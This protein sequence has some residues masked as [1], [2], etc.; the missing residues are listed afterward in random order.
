MRQRLAGLVLM[1]GCV[2]LM[3]SLALAQ[4]ASS[5]TSL[6]GTVKDKDGGVIPGATVTITNNATGVTQTLVTNGEGA[7]ASPAMN[8]GTYTVTIEMSG[9]RKAEYR[10]VRLLGSQ[11]ATINTVLEIGGLTDTVTVTSATDLVRLE[12]PTISSTVSGEFIKSVPA[13]SR[14]ALD[15]MVFLPGVETPGANARE[16]RISGL[17][18][19]TIN[20][21]ID[22]VSTSNNLQS[23]DGFFTMVTPRLD[24]VE[25]VTLT[26]AN[27]GADSSAHGATQV[28][29]VTKSGTNRFK[30]TVYEY[31][32][33][34]SL[35]T[36]TFFNRLNG[37]ERPRAT[38]NT[39]G[40]S[41]GGPI[42][43]PGLFDGRNKAF[44]FF[45]QE[46]SDTPRQQARERLILREGAVN[47]DFRYGVT[48]PRT[49][50]VLALAAANGQLATHDPTVL[51][52][53]NSI[54]AATKTTGTISD[55][56][57]NPNT[58]EYN[59]F[60]PV[61]TTRN[62]PT[63]R[64]DL[65][66][67]S[68]HRLSGTYYLQRYKDSPDTL[69]DADMSFPGFPAWAYQNSYRTTGS[70]AFRSTLSSNLVNEALFGWQSSP[71]DFFGNSHPDMFVHQAGFNTDFNFPTG[72][73]VTQLTNP[74]PGAANAPQPRNTPNFNID[75]N[76]SW[77]KGS[78]SLKFGASFTRIS[79]RITNWNSV[80][81]VGFGFNTTNDPARGVFNTTNF[82]GAS[83]TDLND[84]R[85]L[86]ALL[87][88]R[89]STLPG[90]GRLNDDGTE[91]IYN[92]R[93]TQAERMDEYGFYVS[94]SWRWKPNVTFTLGLRYE[95]QLPMVPTKSTRTTISL[96][97]FCG[98]SGLGQGPGGRECNL[99]N[100]GVLNNPGVVPTYQ[101]YNANAVG[102]KTDKNNL[103]PVL[104]ISYRPNVQKGFLR[105]LLGDPERAVLS[106]GFTR[107]FTRERIDRFTGTF[108][109][110]PGSTVAATRGTG[111]TNFPLVPA[112]ESW[113]L[114][115]R[116]TNRLA[117]PGF[118]QFPTFPITAQTNND[119]G[120][121]D[122][123]IQVGYTDSWSLG[124]QR[125]LTKD[126]AIEVRY[127]GN[128]NYHPW[129]AENW[130]TVDWRNNG[131][132][133]EFK[134]A[135][136]NLLA[137]VQAGRG[138]TFAYFGPGTGTAPLPIFLAHFQGLSPSQAG[139]AANYTSAEFS[140]D[141]WYDN[142]DPRNPD[143]FSI[144]D[145]LY[146]ENSGV[147]RTN[148]RNAGYPLNF[149]VMNP[150]VD[151][152]EIMTTQGGSRYHSLQLDVRR[153]YAQGLQIQG[154]YTYARAYTLTNF[155][156]HFEKKWRRNTSLPHK[157]ALLWVWEL[158]VGRG[159]RF[160]ADMNPWLDGVVGGWQFSGGGRI[161]LPLFRLTNTQLVG[162]SQAEAQKLFGNVRIAVDPVTGATTVWNMPEEVISNSRR[163]YN[164]DPSHPSGY[165]NGEVPE[166][167]YFQRAS[168]LQCQ[169]LFFEDCAEDM[170][171][172]GKWFSNFDFKFVK[173]FPVTSRVNFE[174]NVEVY[175]AFTAKN[176]SQ[177]LN[178]GTGADIFRITSTQSG[179]RRGQVV[180]RLNF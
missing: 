19:Q 164:T 16:S 110:N 69:N 179:A 104:G 109:N 91:Y 45:N 6:S 42:V 37:L 10:E 13:L 4:G 79:N 70:T 154:S 144:A 28:R 17:P 96:Q 129:G 149:W 22:G 1:V 127:I 161:Q 24:A 41:L 114:L 87:T 173:R 166:G 61:Q 115:Y 107:A 89:V 53:L 32:Q 88:G 86:Y 85:A 62:S 125:S 180:F 134:L 99:F 48:T 80:R 64:L 140:N 172:Y 113:P 60:N 65:N 156:L 126:T 157:F 175:N 167:R 105:R 44:F 112:G 77:L 46:I 102:Y 120:I 150:L 142:L 170:F 128:R 54:T 168:S 143:P 132:F 111:A 27:A 73:N 130:N 136:A 100:P 151:E 124:L 34:K 9:F 148:G 31:F 66:L 20:I 123:D 39:Y 101:L 92:G 138:S 103:A 117:I 5:T 59:F 21:T 82:P 30:G 93:L 51:A 15:F 135:Q 14:N 72:N 116:E 7:Y 68:R 163:A 178:P 159:K 139:N 29:F 108:G 90:T 26:T 177:N 153:R 137:N 63:M 47:G 11:P 141:D 174:M 78:H 160:G 56:V 36:N 43:I 67:T 2:W 75:N 33:H 55:N 38:V 3:S 50:N 23:T 133:D 169:A 146:S 118:Q 84:A 74:A 76:L 12:S 57:A 35:N 122:P 119:M 158:P 165:A 18:E 106:S 95:L 155:D 40:A 162:M 49:V 94:D 176:F 98:P 81:S 8:V 25:E 131:L 152:A 83:G 121:F 147:W 71:N 145:D 58:L 97:D 171:F 52:L